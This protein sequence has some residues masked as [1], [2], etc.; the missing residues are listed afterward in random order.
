[1]RILEG[2]YFW[3]D[4]KSLSFFLCN[5]RVRRVWH[6]LYMSTNMHAGAASCIMNRSQSAWPSSVI[7]IVFIFHKLY[8]SRSEC[9]SVQSILTIL[10]TFSQWNVWSQWLSVLNGMRMHVLFCIKWESLCMLGWP[11]AFYIWGHI[12]LLYNTQVRSTILF[13]QYSNMNRTAILPIG[14]R[15]L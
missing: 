3:T 5:L 2:G 6:I 1:M 9:E 15:F 14:S 13:I 8:H 12:C 11:Y 4:A 7:R 10:I